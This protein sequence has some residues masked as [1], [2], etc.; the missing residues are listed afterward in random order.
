MGTDVRLISTTMLSPFLSGRSFAQSRSKK[1]T[2]AKNAL[3]L[4]KVIVD[5][6]PSSLAMKRLVPLFIGLPRNSG[7]KLLALSGAGA[8]AA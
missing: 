5:F 2:V 1:A 8:T 4:G 6:I 3:A 7:I